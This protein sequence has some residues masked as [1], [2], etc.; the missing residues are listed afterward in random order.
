MISTDTKGFFHHS[1]LSSQCEHYEKIF[2]LWSEMQVAK[3]LIVHLLSSS[4]NVSS[5]ELQN[6]WKAKQEKTFRAAN[7]IVLNPVRVYHEKLYEANFVSKFWFVRSFS[8]QHHS[9]FNAIFATENVSQVRIRERKDT[10]FICEVN[11]NFLHSL[12]HFNCDTVF[13][14]IVNFLKES[15]HGFNNIRKGRLKTGF[16]IVKSVQLP[17]YFYQKT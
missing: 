17:K 11:R 8:S 16:Q 10:S 9:K 15:V 1:C 14:V 3:S 4:Y 12:R 7:D 13:A 2:E 6:E 5:F